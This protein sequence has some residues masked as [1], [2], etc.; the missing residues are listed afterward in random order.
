[1]RSLELALRTELQAMMA[2]MKRASSSSTLREPSRIEGMME[3]VY[4]S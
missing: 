2:E 1:M 3:P 4:H